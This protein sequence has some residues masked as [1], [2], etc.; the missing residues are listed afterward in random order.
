[1]NESRLLVIGDDHAVYGLGLL[2]VA[3]RVVETAP[4]ARQALEEAIAASDVD[5]IMLTEQ[6]A[7]ALRDEVDRLRVATISPL[8]LEIPSMDATAARPTLRETVQAALG[9]HL[10]G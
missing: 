3:G 7:N 5:I 1:M 8:I 2:G 4:A 10:E 6:W 9:I